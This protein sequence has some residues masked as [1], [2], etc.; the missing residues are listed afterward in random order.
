MYSHACE[1]CGRADRRLVI[2]SQASI[3]HISE[4]VEI[5]NIDVG[6]PIVES[7]R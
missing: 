6:C 2:A 3:L 5:T 4:G 1:R 7:L